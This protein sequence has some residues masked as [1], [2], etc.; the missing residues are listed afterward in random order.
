MAMLVGQTLYYTLVWKK[1][2]IVRM[3]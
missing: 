2:K 3:V 1:R